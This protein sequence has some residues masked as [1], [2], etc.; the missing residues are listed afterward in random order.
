VTGTFILP[1]TDGIDN[2]SHARIDD[3][4]DMCQRSKRHLD[5]VSTTDGSSREKLGQLRANVIPVE[6]FDVDD[7]VVDQIKNDHPPDWL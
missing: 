4:I 2:A 5:T 7:S 1:F 6:D 3:V